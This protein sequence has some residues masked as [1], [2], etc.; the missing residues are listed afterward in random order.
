MVS[1]GVEVL[2]AGTLRTLVGIGS[3]TARALL[4]AL[5]FGAS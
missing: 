2:T 3:D 1:G 4:D 5:G